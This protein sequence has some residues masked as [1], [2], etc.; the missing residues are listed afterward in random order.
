MPLQRNII[1]VRPGPAATLERGSGNRSV[2]PAALLGEL[3]G[4]VQQAPVALIAA[5]VDI[6]GC[7][8]CLDRALRFAEV[9]AVQETAPAGPAGDLGKPELDVFQG[10]GRRGGV[11]DPDALIRRYKDPSTM[12]RPDPLDDQI[13][14]LREAGYAEADCY[15]KNGIFAVFGGKRRHHE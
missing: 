3:A 14:A 1:P 6:A 13:N 8:R 5:G 7:H 15:Y 2:A 4:E 9:Q 10:H 11:T 12:N